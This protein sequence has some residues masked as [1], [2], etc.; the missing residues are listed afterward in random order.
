MSKRLAASF[1]KAKQENRGILGIFVSAGDPDTN[2]SIKILDGLVES[3]VDMIELGMPFSDPMADGPA[4]QAASLRAIKSGMTLRGSLEIASQFR[5]K[6]AYTPLILMGYYNPIY[7]YGVELFLKDAQA[8]GADGLI[9]VDLPP[10]E[11]VELCNPSQNS[12]L[13]FIR[14]ITPTTLGDR[15][16]HVLEKASGFIYYVSIAGITGTKSAQMESISSAVNR[17]KQVS[18]LPVVT[19]FGIRTA[20]QAAHIA[21]LGDGAIVGSAVVEII[22]E[23]DTQNLSA[24]DTARKVS[25]FTKLLADAI[26]AHKPE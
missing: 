6:H 4:I 15:L 21:S 23:S 19:G 3:G 5:K 20:E 8:A 11:D 1:A 18:D 9:I 26:S 7:R 22:A 2:T 24:E 10:E 25:D 12:E 16:P 17:I 14:L 13:D